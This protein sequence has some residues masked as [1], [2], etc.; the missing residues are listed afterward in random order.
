MNDGWLAQDWNLV[1]MTAGSKLT[2][3]SQPPSVPPP[4]DPKGSYSPLACLARA[5]SESPGREG[6]SREVLADGLSGRG[7]LAG[8]IR[9][10]GALLLSQQTYH[11]AGQWAPGGF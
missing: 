11:G 2:K 9:S 4:C 6:L 3:E 10:H 8:T 5:P 7:P 1:C